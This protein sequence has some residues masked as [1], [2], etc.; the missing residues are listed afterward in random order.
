MELLNTSFYDNILSTW[1]IALL[2][3]IVTVVVLRILKALGVRHIARLAARTETTWDDALVEMLRHTKWLFLLIVALFAGSLL[4]AL[5]V[6]MRGIANAVA[7]VALI[8]Q[9]GIWLNAVILFWLEGY[10]QLKLKEDPASVTTMSAVSFVGR[11]VLWLVILL[12]VLDNLGVNVTALVAGLGVGGIAVALAVQ[13]ILGDLFASLSIILDK[14]FTVGDFLIIDDCMGSVE[15]IGLK[16]TRIRSLSG[17]QLVFSNADLLGSRI[18]NYGRMFERRVVFNLGVTYQTPR[19][20]L[21]KIPTIIRETVEA[22]ASTRFDRSHFKAYGDFSL[23]FET[24]YYVL[25]PDY[26][27]YMDIQQAINLRTHERFEE[28]AIEFAYPTQ[29]LH[30]VREGA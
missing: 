2:V 24:V 4:L 22:Q 28:E 29:T 19:E 17:E 23:N 3:A 18:R 16:T 21:I 9:A 15:H 27:T 10:R 11:L 6:R 30:L 25:V 7:A 5:P 12:L 20:K 13:N 14:P 8:V 26:N 1:L